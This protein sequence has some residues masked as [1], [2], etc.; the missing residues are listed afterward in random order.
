MVSGPENVQF[1]LVHTEEAGIIA[2]ATS[3]IRKGARIISEHALFRVPRRQDD[4]TSP[5][6]GVADKVN[7]LNDNDRATFFNLHN[8]HLEEADPAVGLVMTNAMPL[9]PNS[10]EAG[11]FPICPRLN[12]SC[13]ANAHYSWNAQDQAVNIYATCDITEGKEITVSYIDNKIWLLPH[14]QRQ[15]QIKERFNFLC[16]CKLCTSSPEEIAASDGRR[17]RIAYSDTR[18]NDPRAAKDYPSEAL[19]CCHR[20]FELL[21]TEAEGELQARAPQLYFDAM[22]ICSFNSDYARASLFARLSVE[23]WRTWQGPHPNGIEKVE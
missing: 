19:S 21:L 1:R 10:P 7:V 23:A 20:I 8:S 9:G 16:Q 14:C 15:A 22:Q 18:M 11:I 13:I 3:N 12:H 2:V 17:C 6:S 4:D 5:G